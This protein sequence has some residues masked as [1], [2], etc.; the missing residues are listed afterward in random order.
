MGVYFFEGTLAV[1]DK[2]QIFGAGV[3]RAQLKHWARME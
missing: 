2:L 3:R 1:N